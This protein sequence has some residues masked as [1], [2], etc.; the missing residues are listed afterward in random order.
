MFRVVSTPWSDPSDFNHLILSF[1]FNSE[2]LTQSIMDH[3]HRGHGSRPNLEM[4]RQMQRQHDGHGPKKQ[5]KPHNAVRGRSVERHGGDRGHKFSAR[6]TAQGDEDL[7]DEINKLKATINELA[8]KK[9]KSG[10]WPRDGA[11]ARFS[12][13]GRDGNGRHDANGDGHGHGTTPRRGW[14]HEHQ[15]DGH[16]QHHGHGPAQ[17]AAVDKV[18]SVE[19]VHAEW[20]KLGVA[21]RASLRRKLAAEMKQHHHA[22]RE[23]KVFKPSQKLVNR[24]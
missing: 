18:R 19:S 1:P 14:Q 4:M 13:N 22:N 9:S 7:L 23:R 12:G 3:N 11:P 20:P 24:G 16:G 10:K 15:R 8:A 21:E 2:S 5:N 17:T 6:A